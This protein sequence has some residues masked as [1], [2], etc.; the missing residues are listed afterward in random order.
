[1]EE[2]MHEQKKTVV[3][4]PGTI[5]AA[6]SAVLWLTMP[7]L[8]RNMVIAGTTGA[9]KTQLL[10]SLMRQ[11]IEEGI[12]FTFMTVHPGACE[13]VVRFC[14]AHGIP[15]SRILHFKPGDLSCGVSFDPWAHGPDR[16]S[17]VR[18]KSWLSATADRILRAFLRN[19]PSVDAEQMRRLKRWLKNVLVAGGIEVSGGHLGIDH[20]LLLTDPSHEQFAPLWAKIGPELRRVFPEVH[21][22]F[23]KLQASYARNHDPQRQ[24]AWL[25]STINLLRDMLQPAVQQMFA[26]LSPS[27][28]LREVILQSKVVLLDLSETDDLAREQGKQLG[29]LWYEFLMGEVRRLAEKLPE[30]ERVWHPVVL[31]EFQNYVNESSG[32][33]LGEMR[34]MRCPHICA[35]QDL[36]CLRKGDQLDLVGRFLSNVYTVIT[37][38]LNNPEDAEYLA[39]VFKYSDLDLT[40]LIA[41]HALPDGFEKV[42]VR[43]VSFSEGTSHALSHATSVSETESVSRQRSTAHS[44]QRSVAHALSHSHSAGGSESHTDGGGLTHSRGKA[45]TSSSTNGQQESWGRGSTVGNTEGK[46]VPLL[47]SGGTENKNS[48]VTSSEHSGGGSS[49]SDSQSVAESENLGR[50]VNWSDTEGETWSD[51]RGHTKTRTNGTGRTEGESEG[52]THGI[53]RGETNGET[54]GTTQGLS[55]GCAETY[56]AKTKIVETP[57]GKTVVSV[58]DQLYATIKTIFGL[59]DRMTLCKVRGA[60]PSFTL[61]THWV[62]DPYE[63][64]GKLFPEAFKEEEV[65]WYLS[66]L[67]DAH[68]C[69]FVPSEERRFARLAQFLSLPAPAD[70]PIVVDAEADEDPDITGDG[71][72]QNPFNLG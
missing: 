62:G 21:R 7:M 29:G 15:P 17:L 5:R 16:T 24:E 14:A 72:A 11:F 71:D 69:Y 8:S 70:P 32:D 31:D 40:P 19:V 37:F 58:N 34:K 46:T 59:P 13:A 4:S 67:R 30:E 51:T 10:L 22:D 20:A 2:A 63:E 36:S 44:I 64:L 50:S 23:V 42:I 52:E 56:R 43:N 3:I 25:E 61:E 68:P 18:Y 60:G 9:G 66:Q 39:K 12:G 47:E 27:L 48:A 49:R 53:T 33:N 38:A 65:R 57:N 55:Y 26:Q 6:T 54:H 1:M 28:S 41:P 45:L 35:F